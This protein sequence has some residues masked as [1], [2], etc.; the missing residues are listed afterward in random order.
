MRVE[1]PIVHLPHGLDQAASAESIF[2]FSPLRGG[3]VG[4]LPAAFRALHL[5]ESMHL[6]HSADSRRG[7]SLRMRRRHQ[8]ALGKM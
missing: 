5:M 1:C 4:G 2:R 3:Y 8:L 6:A 7:V